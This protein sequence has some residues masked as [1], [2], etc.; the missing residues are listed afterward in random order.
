MS[1]VGVNDEED[2]A[3]YV[4]DILVEPGTSQSDR[5]RQNDD[6]TL[7]SEYAISESSED[8]FGYDSDADPEYLPTDESESEEEFAEDDDNEGNENVPEDILGLTWGPVDSAELL[9]FQYNE[10]PLFSDETL[11]KLQGATPFQVFQLFADDELFAEIAEQTNLY[12]EQCLSSGEP[13]VKSRL[14]SWL[15]TNTVEIKRF[16]GLIIWMGLMPL[17]SISRYWSTCKL[18]RNEVAKTMPRNRF[19]ILLT[20]LHFC[21]NETADTTNKLYKIQGILD[22]LQEKFMATV[23]PQKEV[24]IDESLIPFRGRLGIRQYIPNKTHRYG[25]KVFKLCVEKG[26]T[27]KVQVY[28][29]KITRDETNATTNVSQ[30]IVMG[31]MEPLLDNGRTLYVDNWYTSVS[32]AHALLARD[33]HLVGTLRKKRKGNPEEVEKARLKKGDIVA[34][35]SETKVVVLKWKDKRDVMMLSTQDIDTTVMV[36][37]K[38]NRDPK[39]K[40]SMVVKYNNA[41]SYIDVSDQYA[42]YSSPLR[43]NIKWYKKLMF[44]L[45]LNT[46]L[47][48]ALVLYKKSHPKMQITKF[49]EEIALALIETEEEALEEPMRTPK[50]LLV[51]MEGPKS[52]ARRRCTQCYKDMVRQHGRDHAQKHGKKVMTKCDKCNLFMCLKCFNKHVNK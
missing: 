45:L 28:Q 14:K 32:L 8:L 46:S 15:P 18:Y 44:E 38:S 50:H 12:A 48:N 9:S 16:F 30:I 25:I 24:F 26:Y 33:T 23:T 21:N 52:K 42:A 7:D 13:S 22:I 43:R 36:Q 31:M 34:R 35:Q 2:L 39:P 47:V 19:Q 4:N 6:N 40:P 5:P 11:Q 49:R 20:M 37:Q 29:G 17:A 10:R 27:W 3:E 41:K 1:F 51:E